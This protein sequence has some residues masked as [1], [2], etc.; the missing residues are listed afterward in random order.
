MDSELFKGSLTQLVAYDPERA[1]ELLARWNQDTEF[2]RDYDFPPVRPRDAKRMQARLTE[3]HARV[4]PA[5]LQFHIALLGDEHIVG[6]C[7]LERNQPAHGEAYAAIGIG[8]RA[9]WGKGFGTDA[10]KLLLAF[11][12]R[13]WNLHRVSLLVFGYN[14]RALRS[15]EKCGFRVEGRIRNQVKRGGER[16]DSIVM[17]ILRDEWA[18]AHRGNRDAYRIG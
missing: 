17:G 7:E 8:E 4:Q 13:E 11:G 18:N 16:Y 5:L 10:M 9:Y 6:E 1:G 2:S 12:F 15:Y 3:Q 14:P